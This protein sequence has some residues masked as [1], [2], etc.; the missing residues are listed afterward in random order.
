MSSTTE[1]TAARGRAGG[2]PFQLM[3]Q[4]RAAY[5]L[6][7]LEDVMQSGRIPAGD[8]KRWTRRLPAMIQVNGFGQAVAFYYS[9][10]QKWSAVEAVYD[11]LD[12]WLCAPDGYA[13][14]TGSPVYPTDGH[15]GSRLL[16]GITRQPQQR[17]RHAQAE[18][19]A[20]L[21]WA[22]KFVEALPRG[23]DEPSDPG[24]RQ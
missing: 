23:D 21:R 13:Q 5:A 24:S 3:E 4:A 11:L 12:G 7:W 15:Q 10:R 8:L 20:L 18:S 19:Q 17:Y 14:V 2:A 22:K 6:G 9:R 1:R 16:H